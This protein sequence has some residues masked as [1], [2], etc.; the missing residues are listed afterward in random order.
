MRLKARQELIFLTQNSFLSYENRSLEISDVIFSVGGF[1]DKKLFGT[2]PRVTNSELLITFLLYKSS[3][4]VPEERKISPKSLK[5]LI[6]A[7][8]FF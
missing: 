7:T 8:F 1:I 3:Q 6:K 2:L 5:V 4:L